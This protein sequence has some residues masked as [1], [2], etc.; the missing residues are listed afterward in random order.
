[1]NTYLLK[2]Q[3]K[4]YF[5][6]LSIFINLVACNVT[7]VYPLSFFFSLFL[8]LSPLYWSLMSHNLEYDLSDNP[9]PTYLRE[10]ILD[11]C[12]IADSFADLL[13]YIEM[14]ISYSH[15]IWKIFEQLAYVIGFCVQGIQMIG[16]L[17]TILNLNRN[18]VCGKVG[19]QHFAE[20][21]FS[22]GYF[23][24][25]NMRTRYNS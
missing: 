7:Q 21:F 15:P 9:I 3:V 5:S 16:F 2:I 17:R 10:T 23:F 20:D 13:P 4:K 18:Q 8:Q 6:H 19:K 22:L 25:L 14:Q 11:R 12:I 1:M 24:L